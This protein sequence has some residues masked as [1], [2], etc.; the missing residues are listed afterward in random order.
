MGTGIRIRPIHIPRVVS[1]S[2]VDTSTVPYLV[3]L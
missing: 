2:G 1:F 3:K